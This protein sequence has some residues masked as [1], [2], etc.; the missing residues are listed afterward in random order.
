[1]GVLSAIDTLFQR[2]ENPFALEEVR[3]APVAARPGALD[4]VRGDPHSTASM[5]F[6]THTEDGDVRLDDAAIQ[7][8]ARL[9]AGLLGSAMEIDDGSTWRRVEARDFAVLCRTNRSALQVQD[10]LRAYGVPAVFQG[11]K[12]VFSSD[13]ALEL[14]SVL[15]GLLEPNAL[16]QLRAALLTSICGVRADELLNGDSEAVVVQ[17]AQR[18][19]GARS[20]WRSAGVIRALR[21]LFDRYEVEYTMLQR[22]D[23]ER[24]LTDLLHLTEL[25]H[26]AEHDRDLGPERLLDWFRAA[27]A[28]P[29]EVESTGL[30]TL[31]MRLET[32]AD[33]TQ[34]FTIH[35]SKGL[36]FPMVVCP[37][38]VSAPF[39]PNARLFPREYHEGD[40]Q[41]IE[42]ET[43]PDPDVLDA[44]RR[45]YDSENRRLLYVALTRA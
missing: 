44:A 45:E 18:F 7:T 15:G 42:F 35:T 39:R 26:Q 30:S 4:G 10:A 6:I 2:R 19:L 5:Q 34:L 9:I 8:T 32:D 38:L 29:S 20:H 12:S 27:C 43:Q 13:T 40:E 21:E 31:Q 3:F 41:R 16:S 1:P 25:L 28:D 23:G 14:A 11:D 36:E 37:D 22:F 17:H 33:A 24:R